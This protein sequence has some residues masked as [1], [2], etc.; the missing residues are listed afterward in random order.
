VPESKAL[1]ASLPPQHY[2]PYAGPPYPRAAASEQSEYADYAAKHASPQVAAT[3]SQ[4]PAG[5]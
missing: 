2:V 1:V 3:A 4:P 5:K